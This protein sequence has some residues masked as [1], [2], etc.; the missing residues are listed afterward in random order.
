MR[1]CWKFLLSGYEL[2]AFLRSTH[3]LHGKYEYAPWRHQSKSPGR[4][5]LSNSLRPRTLCEWRIISYSNVCKLQQK[6]PTRPIKFEKRRLQFGP[7]SFVSPH[8]LLYGY[9]FA[10]SFVPVWNLFLTLTAQRWLMGFENRVQRKVPR[11]E[12]EEEE[13]VTALWRKFHD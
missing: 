9:N 7:D 13:E 11:P 12:E 1:S 4:N 8:R 10:R 2:Q 3:T 6:W 5:V